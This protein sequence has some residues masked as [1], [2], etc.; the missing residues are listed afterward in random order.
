MPVQKTPFFFCFVFVI[1]RCPE[2]VS[3]WRTHSH[4]KTRLKHTLTEQIFNTPGCLDDATSS[5]TNGHNLRHPLGTFGVFADPKRTGFPLRFYLRFYLPFIGLMCLRG[6]ENLQAA[7]P[8]LTPSLPVPHYHPQTLDFR[9]ES[10]PAEESVHS[11]THSCTMTTGRPRGLLKTVKT[12][13]S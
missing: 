4:V 7:P 10:V 12:T 2:R 3:K 11:H 13:K 9:Q 1:L 8:A 5:N 6:K